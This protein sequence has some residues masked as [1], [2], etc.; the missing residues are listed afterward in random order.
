M[1]G[2]GDGYVREITKALSACLNAAVADHLIAQNPVATV[3]LPRAPQR[4]ATPWTAQM[5]Q[6]VRS[7]LPGHYAATV[8]A[9]AGL[10][11]RQGEVFG[12]AAGDIEWMRPAR[13]AR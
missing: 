7:A 6:E 3:V 12:L 2:L 13:A 5:V 8:D 9:G 4:R 11:L 10:G 1:K